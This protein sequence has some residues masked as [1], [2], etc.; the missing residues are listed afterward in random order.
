MAGRIY[1]PNEVKK[2]IKS[3]LKVAIENAENAYENACEEEDALTGQ[4][5]FSLKCKQKRVYVT[6]LSDSQ[7]VQPGVWKW[8]FKYYKFRG[9]G[10]KPTENILGADGIFE[11]GVQRGENFQKKSLLFQ[12]KNDLENDKGLYL[13][14]IKLSNWREAAFVINFTPK[15][16]E[17]FQL[18]DVLKARGSRKRIQNVSSL[19]KVLSEQYID[20][21]IGDTDLEYD[22]QLH[23]LS[24]RDYD[25]KTI[26]TK[27]NIKNR[28][29]LKII[30]PKYHNYDIGDE[31]PNSEVYKHRM[32][33]S[34]EDLF[35]LD[36]SFT[37]SELKKERNK[38]VISYHPD[39]NRDLDDLHM[40]ILKR[41]MQEAN[42]VY[43]R[44]RNEKL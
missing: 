22:A 7:D 17:A 2:S 12:S 31:I 19:Y 5:G 36:D 29:R 39:L 44:L 11:F 15:S 13:Q 14:A 21:H 42:K 8:S 18:D 34:D 24:W 16:I 32:Y 3:H 6:S 28:I 35:A 1:I 26:N 37:E 38:Y 23:R 20:C 4:L 27:F 10:P 41:R 33:V 43:E 40:E 25:N 9:R 30:P